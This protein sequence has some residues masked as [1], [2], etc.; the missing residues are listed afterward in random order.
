MRT[1]SWIVPG[2]QTIEVDDV[3]AL[4]MQLIGGRATVVAEDV[5]GARV[6]VTDVS[7]HPLEVRLDGDRLSVGY[8]FLGWD[9][10]LKRLHSYRAK[11]SADVRIV[12]P[13]ATEVKIGTVLAEVEVSGLAENL[14]VG[15]A[16]GAVHVS[17]T[18]GSVDVKTV[19][20][21]VRV[22]DHEGTARI[23]SVSGTVLARG[24]MPRAEVST[25]SGAVT[26]ANRLE[27]SVV[28]VN[29]VSARIAVD[30][31]AGCG[32]VLTARSVSGKAYVDGIDRSAVGVS[33]IE[34]KVGDTGC[35]LSTNTVSGDLQVRRAA[36]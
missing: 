14:G 4:R 2:A 36:S 22:E 5:P 16:A 31:P 18:R 10:W 21:A 3:S 33:S 7:G 25:V 24:T 32:L 29:T 13:R 23:S 8:P 17:G 28:T 9:G 1:T 30:L 35:W 26:V 15:T 6:E 19:S 27:T 12:L 34:E 11:D 20:G